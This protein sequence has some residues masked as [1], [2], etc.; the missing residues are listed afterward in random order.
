MLYGA[1]VMLEWK[2][3][4]MMC[5]AILAVLSGFYRFMIFTGRLNSIVSV[6]I[7]FVGMFLILM[8]YRNVKKR[9]G[10]V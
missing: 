6:F 3:L 8:V 10:G 2:D 1:S 4:V 5:L 7:I 9:K